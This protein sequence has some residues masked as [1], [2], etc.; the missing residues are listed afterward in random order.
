MKVLC[1]VGGIS[2]GSLN[3]RLYRAVKEL[4]PKDLEISDFDISQLPFFSQD[5][6][7][8]APAVVKDLKKQITEADIV[9]FV[10]P[11]YNHSIPGVLKNAI[12]WGSRPYPQNSWKDKPAG[13]IGT[14]SGATGTYGA[15][16]HLRQVLSALGMF[17][18]PLPEFMMNGSK[19]FDSEGKLTDEKSKEFLLK[20]LTAF[21]AWGK[22]F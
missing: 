22:K 16:H 11:E 7:N 20:Y 17:T 15:Q 14:S 5:I 2:K 18:L 10:T 9:L 1:L 12:D 21:D 3:K 4:A 13:I 19:A 6:E 8:D